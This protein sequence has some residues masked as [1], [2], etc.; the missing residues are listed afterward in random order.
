M[1]INV[2]IFVGIICIPHESGVFRKKLRLYLSLLSH[3]LSSEPE[4]LRIVLRCPTPWE[5]LD[6]EVLNEGNANPDRGGT[7]A[8]V[9]NSQ[10]S[11]PVHGLFLFI[12]PTSQNQAQQ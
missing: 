1:L 2:L 4:L 6:K 3:T 7:V 5:M 8:T 10:L 12:S 9:A 11:S